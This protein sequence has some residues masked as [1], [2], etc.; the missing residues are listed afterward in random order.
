MPIRDNIL[1]HVGAPCADLQ[2]PCD[3]ATALRASRNTK[4]DA[5]GDPIRMDLKALAGS[6]AYAPV[7]GIG[8]Y[9]SEAFDRYTGGGYRCSLPYTEL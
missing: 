6:T 3:T 1:H 2:C 7:S 8:N 9:S 4:Y 5:R